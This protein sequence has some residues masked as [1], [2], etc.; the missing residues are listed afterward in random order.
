M[1]VRDKLLAEEERRLLEQVINTERAHI[2]GF[3]SKTRKL[4]EALTSSHN[5]RCRFHHPR[6]AVAVS[7]C[8]TI[9]ARD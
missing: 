1:T 8:L 5:V 6:I 4:E 3:E 7:A 2:S 9:C